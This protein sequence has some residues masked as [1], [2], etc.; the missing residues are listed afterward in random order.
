MNR[1]ILD[2]EGK[3]QYVPNYYNLQDMFDLYYNTSL[4]IN[5]RP[6]TSSVIISSDYNLP[7]LYD[8]KLYSLP[9]ISSYKT[10]FDVNNDPE[11]RYKVYKFFYQEYKEM[12]LKY[13]YTKLVKFFININDE[14]KMVKSMDEYHNNTNEKDTKK[15]NFILKNIFGKNEMLVFLDKFVKKNN[16]KWYDLKRNFEDEIKSGI[17]YK[18]KSHIKKLIISNS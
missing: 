2:S 3:I 16:L 13:D 7:S 11:L 14:I 10:Y 12:W 8:Y 9:V 6:D 5:A 1:T 15:Y 4:F 18:I 17:Y